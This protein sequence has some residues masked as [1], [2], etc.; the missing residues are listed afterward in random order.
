MNPAPQ[1]ATAELSDA[2]LDNVSG[3]LAAGGSAGLCVETPVAAV[4][5]DVLAVATHE[6][7]AAGTAVQAATL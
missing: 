4:A 6:G 1:V 7:V 2:A 5:T 3:G